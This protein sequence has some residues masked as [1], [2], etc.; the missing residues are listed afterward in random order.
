MPRGICDLLLGDGEKNT[1]R[2][3]QIMVNSQLWRHIALQCNEFQNIRH[4]ESTSL[5]FMTI[6]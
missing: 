2:K 4:I 1:R 3:I 5:D 6:L